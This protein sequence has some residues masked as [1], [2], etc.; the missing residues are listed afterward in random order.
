MAPLCDSRGK[1]RYFIGAQV[2]V[3]GLVKDCTEMESLQRLLEDENKQD[4][5]EE[6]AEQT[7]VLNRLNG[8]NGHTNGFKNSNDN[9]DSEEEDEFRS[10]SEMFNLG[11][12]STVRKY[13]GRMHTDKSID[14]S[15]AGSMHKP[16]LLLRDS[17]PDQ[18]LRS[19][20]SFDNMHSAGG[21]AGRL[22]GKLSG[23]YKH[24][25]LFYHTNPSCFSP[26]ATFS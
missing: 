4:E 9:T 20:S 1:I 24:V 21:G 22:S 26:I 10:L 2:D 23:V 6:N 19:V 25:S 13:G 16:R 7:D 5:G 14:D 8:I 3:S 11:E 15:E 18:T 17:S 12:L